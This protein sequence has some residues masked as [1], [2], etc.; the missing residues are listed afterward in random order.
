MYIKFIVY[1]Y[2]EDTAT[3]ISLYNNTY[4]IQYTFM[5]RKAQRVISAVEDFSRWLNL[6]RLH[7]PYFKSFVNCDKNLLV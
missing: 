7:Y 4:T 1:M 6:Q 3:M 5:H 2:I